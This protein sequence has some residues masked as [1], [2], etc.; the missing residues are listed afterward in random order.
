M[1]NRATVRALT[2]IVSDLFNTYD[3][4]NNL[5]RIIC[6]DFCKAFD[7]TDHNVLLQKFSQYEIPQLV[8]VW[9]LYFMN[10]CSQFLRV[11]DSV[12]NLLTTASGAGCNRIDCFGQCLGCYAVLYQGMLQWQLAS[13]SHDARVLSQW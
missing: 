6:I 13:F 7:L 11:G 8:L 12:S 9:Y 5:I 1:K 4:F 3:S 10:N 2:K